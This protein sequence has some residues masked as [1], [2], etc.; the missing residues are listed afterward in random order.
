VIGAKQPF[1]VRVV[2]VG[3]P[4]LDAFQEA[5]CRNYVAN[6]GYEFT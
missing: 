2:L 5:E 6:S 1:K 3:E 4:P